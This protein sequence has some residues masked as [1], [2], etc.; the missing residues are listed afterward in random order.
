MLQR[1]LDFSKRERLFTGD[2]HLLALWEEIEESLPFWAEEWQ[3][4][5]RTVLEKEGYR[6]V[7][8]MH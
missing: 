5:V 4:T 2:S 1:F 6:P 7:F 3:R 8:S